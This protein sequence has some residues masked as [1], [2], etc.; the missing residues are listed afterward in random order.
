MPSFFQKILRFVFKLVL[1]VFAAIFAVSLLLAALIVVTLSLVAALLTG[2][3][4]APA[5]VFGRF[6]RYSPDGMWPGNARRAEPDRAGAHDVV[7]VEVREVGRD[8]P[9]P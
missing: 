8:K 9:A 1:G 6:Q 3:K 2:R 4:P 5:Q 7:D